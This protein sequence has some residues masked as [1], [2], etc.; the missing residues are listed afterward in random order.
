MWL[1]N[2]AVFQRMAPSINGM[3]G[4]RLWTVFDETALASD[5]PDLRLTASNIHE[6]ETLQH[7]MR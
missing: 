3:G 5:P 1:G 4:G 7:R 2:G 6:R